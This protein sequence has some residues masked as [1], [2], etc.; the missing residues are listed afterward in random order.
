MLKDSFRIFLIDPIR[1]LLSDFYSYITYAVRYTLDYVMIKN[2]DIG[3]EEILQQTFK[4]F[5]ISIFI[6][7]ANFS[8]NEIFINKDS[9]LARELKSEIGYLSVFYISFLF[10]YYISYFY[11][12]ITSNKIHNVLVIRTWIMLIFLQILF[13]QISGDLN[14]KIIKDKVLSE[15]SLM[16]YGILLLIGIFHIIKSIKEKRIKW[17]D[18]V[19]YLFIF[20][21]FFIFIAIEIAIFDGLFN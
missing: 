14:K 11:A 21:S 16:A 18:S 6:V 9:D 8:Y 3:K 4:F 1:N 12:N 15:H 2:V 13:F 10:Y 17:Y 7:L 5:K 19:F 20:A